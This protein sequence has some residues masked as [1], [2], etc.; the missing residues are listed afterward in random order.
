MKELKSFLASIHGESDV[1]VA[2]EIGGL[3]L[4]ERLSSAQFQRLLADLPGDR[5]REALLV[6][7]DISAF[8][9][10]PPSEIPPMEIPDLGSQRKIM[11][12]AAQYVR[13]T[14]HDLPNFYA[15]R[16]TTTFRREVSSN[17]PIRLVTTYSEMEIYRDGHELRK[18]RPGSQ[19]AGLTTSG[20]FGPVL[21]TVILDSARGNLTWSHW[22][23]GDTGA[24]AVFRYAVRA[25]EL[26]Y[27]VQDK[28][29]AYRGEI[30]IDADSGTISRIVLHADPGL[31]KALAVA[32]FAVEYGLVELGG[33][34]YICPLKGIAH[35]TDWQLRWLNDVAFKDYHLFR[36]EMRILPG[37]EEVQ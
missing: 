8:H 28:A 26:H 35:S 21:G 29:R 36:P 37:F 7:A 19:T 27:V 14:Q 34:N 5:S 1:Q 25:K 32:D 24:Q 22:E 13:K 2:T 23:E 15:T 20:E 12:L 9:D 16:V 6:L 33:K 3:E 17:R 4:T 18:L 31:P 11:L 10:P 30:A